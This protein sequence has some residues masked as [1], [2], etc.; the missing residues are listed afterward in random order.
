MIQLQ[1]LFSYDRDVFR[2]DEV[3]VVPD[4]VKLI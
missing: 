4:D 3:V 2:T 1:N